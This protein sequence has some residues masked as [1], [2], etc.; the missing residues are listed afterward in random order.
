MDATDLVDTEDYRVLIDRLLRKGLLRGVRRN[1]DRTRNSPRWKVV[2]PKDA[3]RYYGEL[4]QAAQSNLDGRMFERRDYTRMEDRLS[5]DSP[6][7]SGQGLSNHLQRLGLTDGAGY[8]TGPLKALIESGGHEP[9]AT[10]SEASRKTP[11]T[12]RIAPSNGQE[13][14]QIQ[15]TSTSVDP[16]ELDEARSVASERQPSKLF[17]GG[18]AY[19]AAVDDVRAA[20]E[21]VG[22]VRAV[23]VPRDF[24]RPSL[25]RGYAFVEMVR[26]EDAKTAKATLDGYLL[27]GRPIQLDWAHS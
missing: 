7:K 19:G 12:S 21:A 8:P 16:D 11:L 3:N 15:E 14:D 10:G 1:R 22:P 18:L 17:I 13:F 2:Q 23:N 9:A 27:V 5:R 24:Q 6:Y 26:P 4:L 25:N 20:F